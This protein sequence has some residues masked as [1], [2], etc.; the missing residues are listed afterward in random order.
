V[1]AMD[2]GAGAYGVTPGGMR[3]FYITRG[4]RGLV[5]DDGTKTWAYG[6]VSAHD[7]D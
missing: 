1:E 5:F 4:F 7:N 3:R 6:N 2:Y